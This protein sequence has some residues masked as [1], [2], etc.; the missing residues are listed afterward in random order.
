MS[1]MLFVLMLPFASYIAALSVI[2]DE[3]EITN[4][5]AGAIFSAYLAG[6]AVSA[7]LVIPL[8]DRLRARP[9]F[10][11]AAAISVASNALF[12]L[13]ADGL[14]SGMALRALAGVGM[15]GIYMPGVRII[16]ERV[17]NI[18]R[19]TAVGM[20][21]TAQYAA[22]S[23]SLAATGGLMSA[24]DWRDAYLV[25]SLASMLSLPL[26]LPLLRS[27][28]NSPTL[29][30]SGRLDLTVL[31]SR[32]ARYFIM[33]YSLHALELYAVRVWL[34]VFLT[35]VLIA[36]GVDDSQAVVK[37]ATVVGIAFGAAS[38]GPLVGGVISNRWGRA[39]SAAAIFALSGACSWLIGWT[40]DLPWVLIIGLTVVYGWA[41]SADSAIYSTAITELADPDRLGSM[42]AVQAFLGFMGGVVGPILLGGVLDVAPDGSEWKVGFSL[43]GL[44]AAA[45]IAGLLRVR[46]VPLV[47]GYAPKESGR[48]SPTI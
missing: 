33:G 46:S 9:V 26:M 5:E 31:K 40:G 25:M 10:L 24:L 45:A 48:P 32:T 38:I 8:T 37:A 36:R 39:T 20:F 15:V 1:F 22:Q 42:M 14:Y 35:A 28:V 16:A 11:S 29:G 3:W 4:I 23:A 2:Q 6:Y 47:R 30:S 27:H 18:G 13:L 34:P 7:L 19:G 41:I 12:P 17:P 43:V 44:I 21:V